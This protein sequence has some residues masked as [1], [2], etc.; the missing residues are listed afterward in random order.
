MP[1]THIRNWQTKM[2]KRM[3]RFEMRL[4]KLIKQVEAIPLADNEKLA[5]LSR[6]VGRLCIRD[7]PE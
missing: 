4:N 7:H 1:L 2:E 5:Q 6:Q 3:D